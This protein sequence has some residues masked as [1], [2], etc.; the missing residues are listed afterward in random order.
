MTAEA[1]AAPIAPAAGEVDFAG[2]APSDQIAAVRGDN[3]AD[4]LMTRTTAEAIIPPLE[5]E[6]GVADS[7]HQDPDQREAFPAPGYGSLTD[8][9]TTLFEVDGEHKPPS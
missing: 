3:F 4:E 5:L 7:G 1:A 2:D 9:D 6:V 8:G